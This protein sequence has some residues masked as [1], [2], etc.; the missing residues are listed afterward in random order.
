[1]TSRF[2]F[3]SLLL[4]LGATQL[5]AQSELIVEPGSSFL[6]EVIAADT[7]TTGER[8]DSNRIYVL[9]RDAEYLVRGQ[10]RNQT[11]KLHLRAEEGEG[12]RPHIKTFPDQQGTINGD[13]IRLY[14]DGIFENLHIDGES[15]SGDQP[16]PNRLFRTE[17]EGQNLTVT[18]CLLTNGAQSAVRV[19]K[20]AGRIIF[21]NNV[22]TNLGAIAQDNMGNGRV[23]DARSSSINYL[24]LENC[25]F[26]NVMDRLIRHR[27]GS[28]VIDSMVVN[29]TTTINHMGYHGFLELG[30]MGDYFQFTNNL[31]LDGMS[32]GNDVTDAE[33]LTEFDSHGETDA[34]G[35]P[36]M[37]WIGSIPNDTTEFV[38]DD[39]VY[40]VSDE[41]QAW[42]A[43]KGVDEGPELLLTDHIAG[44]LADGSMAFTKVQVSVNE[45]P[46][47]PEELQ[48]WYWSPDGA[49][50]AK[51]TTGEFTMNR[52]D[53]TYWRE[54]LDGGYAVNDS[55]RNEAGMQLG[56]LNW[57]ENSVNTNDVLVN[58][59]AMAT[60]PNPLADVAT[61]TFELGEASR[62]D[63]QWFDAMGRTVRVESFGRLNAGS[64]RRQIRRDALAPGLYFLQ[65]RSERERGT[66]RIVVR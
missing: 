19:N 36:T 5:R 17:G 41:L 9:R 16:Y 51:V 12:D 56:D 34:E 35:R 38:I 66:L 13:M 46:M 40:S 7:T 65:V 64:H 21:E 4:C 63:L 37:V 29:H 10:F 55:L 8:V 23:I 59:V 60:Y 6:N 30:N 49:N 62:V 54:T 48:D 2:T 22:I 28:G 20:A 1:M 42:Y 32:M 18:G 31:I 61:L 25:T 33:R 15:S 53:A 57:V 11:Y 39:N 58:Q 47:F 24:R 45:A 14:A 52:Q 43:E 3:L 27:G 50:K 44:R 26:V